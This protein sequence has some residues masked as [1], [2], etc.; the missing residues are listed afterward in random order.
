VGN[1]LT[2]VFIL[3]TRPEP[4]WPFGNRPTPRRI[5]ALWKSGVF[6]ACEIS[7]HPLGCEV[8]F[9]EQ[10]E[11]LL[12]RVYETSALAEIEAIDRRR[13]LVADGWTEKPQM[14]A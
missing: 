6:Q 3:M 8:R 5:W 14:P 11:L 4:G 13:E 9:Y 1:L 10:G 7:G 2:A 12:S